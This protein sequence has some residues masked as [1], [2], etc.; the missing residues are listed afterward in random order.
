MWNRLVP[1]EAEKRVVG[2]KWRRLLCPKWII[3]A[4]STIPVPFQKIRKHAN[5]VTR[6]TKLEYVYYENQNVWAV[7][8]TPIE[9][10]ISVITII[11]ENKYYCHHYCHPPLLFSSLLSSPSS[12]TSSS[13]SECWWKWG[14]LASL[15]YPHIPRC[16]PLCH[17]HQHIIII[18]I[19]IITIIIISLTSFFAQVFVSQL[20]AD[21]IKNLLNLSCQWWSLKMVASCQLQRPESQIICEES[22]IFWNTPK[23]PFWKLNAVMNLLFSLT[24][25]QGKSDT[26]V[27]QQL[28]FLT[29]LASIFALQVWNF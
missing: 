5:K 4:S 26:G 15:Q 3:S 12:L 2:Q 16:L 18:I 10:L 11:S 8:T 20:V 17:H 27:G 29:S 28:Q 9:I 25:S 14:V 19:D 23:Y 7:V 6:E 21:Q 13:G 1:W 22:D 24:K